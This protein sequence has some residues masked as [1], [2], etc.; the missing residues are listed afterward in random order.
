MSN[1]KESIAAGTD[2][3]PPMLE[4]ITQGKGEAQTQVIRDKLDEEFTKN[5]TSKEIWD[6]VELLMKGLGI[7]VQQK[8]EVMFDEYKRFRANGNESIH[9]YFVRLHKLIN[10]MKITTLDIPVHQTNTKFVNNLPPYWTKYVTN[11]KNNKYFSK[12]NQGYGTMMNGKGQL[13]TCYNCR[14]QGHV[15]RQCKEKKRA[16]DSQWFKDKILLMESKEKGAT[17][18]AEAEAFLR[19]VECTAHY[20]EPL[21]ITTTTTFQVS[22]EDEYDYDVEEAPHAAIAFM[23]SLTQTGTGYDQGTSYD[24][25]LSS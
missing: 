7:S 21:A 11:V 13:V 6:N 15:A 3:R 17:L 24:S 10:D 25:D 8:K 22:H 20:D 1:D 5:K 12:G 4:E 9:D 2:N 19:N 14:G 18:D 16:K 23:A